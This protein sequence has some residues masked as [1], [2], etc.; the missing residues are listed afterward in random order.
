MALPDS[1]KIVTGTAIV[2]AHTT[3]SPTAANN[4]GSRTDQLNLTS[5]AAGAA[6]QSIK[7]DFGANRAPLWVLAAGI[8]MATAADAGEAVDFYIGFSSNATAGTANPG[9]LSGADAAYTGYNA[10]LA[11]SLKDLTPLSALI[12]T[13]DATTVVLIDTEITTFRATERYGSL[14]V[15]NNTASDAF[16]ADAVEMAIRLTPLEYQ[17]QD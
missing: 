7:F 5:I 11:D 10:N 6:R 8:E 16:V 14:V 17:V 13:T 9:G 15:V 1:M 2:L 12:L 3:Y 4:L